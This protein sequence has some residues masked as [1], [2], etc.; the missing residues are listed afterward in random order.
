MTLRTF[1]AEDKAGLRYMDTKGIQVG[2]QYIVPDFMMIGPQRTGTTWLSRH[3]VQHPEVFIPAEKELYYFNYLREGE[4]K[5][6]TSRK[7]TW[8]LNKFKPSL[9][10]FLRLNAMNLKMM[11]RLPKESLDW[12]QYHKASVFGEATASYA[13][14][15]EDLIAEIFKLNPN[16]KVVMMVRNPIE[17]AWSHAKKDLLKA[18]NRTMEEVSFLEFTEFYQRDYQKQCGYYHKMIQRWS[19]YVKT[20]YFLIKKFSDV[21]HKPMQLFDDVCH[22]LDIQAMS[23][24][25]MQQ[26]A[27]VNPTERV[28]LPE[29]HKALLLS[30]FADEIV[31]LKEQGWL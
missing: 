21:K 2:K 26:Q 4:G 25:L 14:M 6:F 8:Y 17:R 27:V 3:L 19:K 20:D 13:A 18:K 10:D 29:T 23:S 24:A 7:L 30:L 1:S 22:F 31:Y 5:L 15:D 12:F 11:G 28:D 9:K 16:M